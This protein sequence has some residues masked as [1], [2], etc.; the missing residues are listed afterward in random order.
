M[1]QR[2]PVAV[3]ATHGFVAVLAGAFAAHGL[4]GTLPADALGWVQTGAHYQLVHAVALLAIAVWLRF[5]APPAARHAWWSLNAGTLLFSVSLYAMA[6][7]GWRGL[8]W[9]TPVGGV[10]M[11]AGWVLLV[12]A[13]LTRSQT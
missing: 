10:L 4:R 12:R 8:A 1:T 2:V 11:L 5:G 7:S 13:G 3:A 9:V 6:L